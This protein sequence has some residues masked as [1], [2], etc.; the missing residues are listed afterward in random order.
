MPLAPQNGLSTA[1]LVL[2]IIAV[3]IFCLWPVSIPMGVLAVI[4]GV[5]GRRRAGRGESNNPGQAL[6]G[7]ICGA[8][9]A[10]L[11]VALMLFIFLAP[12]DADDDPWPTDE[13]GYSTSLTV[14]ATR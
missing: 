4:L 3:V 5:V 11:G 6:A 12:D 7:I 8:V 13:G 9:A 2:G 10:L 14:S 1:S